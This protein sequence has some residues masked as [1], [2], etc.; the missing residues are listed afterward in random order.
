MDSFLVSDQM[1]AAAI[2]CMQ[3]AAV[4]DEFHELLKAG[5]SVA[6]LLWLW[7]AGQNQVPLLERGSIVNLQHVL[8][9]RSSAGL[10]V[11]H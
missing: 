7:K 4:D 9:I 6:G 5:L 3:N 1:P 2:G 10:W 11:S 8:H